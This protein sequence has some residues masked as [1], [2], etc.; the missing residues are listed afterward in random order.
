MLGYNLPSELLERALI[1]YELLGKIRHNFT[2]LKTISI[3]INSVIIA[4]TVYLYLIVKFQYQSDLHSLESEKELLLANNASLNEV[5]CIL[6]IKC[7][8]GQFFG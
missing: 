8:H 4:G 7:M 6:Y 2:G 5:L 1:R 3:C